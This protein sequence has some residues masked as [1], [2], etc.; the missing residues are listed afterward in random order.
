M[1]KKK[2]KAVS[3]KWLSQEEKDLIREWRN[4]PFVRNMMFSKNTISKEEHRRYIESVEGDEHR[5]LY[6]FYLDD[7]PFA[8]F[9]YT[10]I[11]EGMVEVG[12]YLIDQCYQD[13]GY[14]MIL[15]YMGTD[16]VFN[17]LD[18]NTSIGEVLEENKKVLSINKKFG[19]DFDGSFTKTT[20]ETVFRFH[21][22][23]KNWNN[24][25]KKFENII[26]YI[27]NEVDIVH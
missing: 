14:G 13:M 21:I 1:D 23:K 7:V 8:V 27:V 9:N 22:T 19:A 10:E 3:L 17:S 2:F 25:K 6:V 18:Y 12:N 15:N 11:D 4:K 20:G 26:Y 24:T 5:D 16:L